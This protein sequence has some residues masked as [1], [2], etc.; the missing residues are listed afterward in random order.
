MR[1]SIARML[2][3][4][5]GVFILVSFGAAAC[6]TVE[7]QRTPEGEGAGQPPAAS[8]I[9]PQASTVPPASTVLPTSRR[10][11]STPTATT[12]TATRSPMP[13][14]S[15][16]PTLATVASKEIGLPLMLIYLGVDGHNSGVGVYSLD[17]EGRTRKLEHLSHVSEMLLSDDGS[18]VA[19]VDKASGQEMYI[20]DPGEPYQP[21]GKTPLAI[22]VLRT[23][24]SG[25]AARLT[26]EEL[27]SRFFEESE[28]TG[29]RRATYPNTIQFLPD[30]HELVFT[31]DAEWTE[32]LRG[33]PGYDDLVLM[34]GDTGELT[35][36]AA[37]LQDLS[38]SFGG[39][40]SIAPDGEYVL[41][42]YPEHINLIPTDG[43]RGHPNILTYERVDTGSDYFIYAEPVWLPDSSAAGVWIPCEQQMSPREDVSCDTKIWRILPREARAV[44]VG[45]FSRRP[46]RETWLYLSPDLSQTAILEAQKREW[47]DH[48]IENSLFLGGGDGS[49]GE[50][51]AQGKIT[52]TGWAPDAIHFMYWFGAEPE[53]ELTLMLGRID[54]D[55]EPIAPGA[56]SLEW[57]PDGRH[58]LYSSDDV[59]MLAG[60]DHP[61][62]GIGRGGWGTW[63]TEESYLFFDSNS[64]AHG[65]YLLGQI[66][67][68]MPIP[69]LP[70]LLDDYWIREIDFALVR[71]E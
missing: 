61:P 53:A 30:S 39:P 37:M 32:W 3:Q 18:L 7:E 43:P 34:D 66:G 51:Y 12:P 69:L 10:V 1:P 21:E 55:P 46:G 13:S 38:G 25:V 59:L 71:G 42:V 23:D 70:N 56:R 40:V 44:L 41:T 36:L 29:A 19:L 28:F 20:Q 33:H 35:D 9:S 22:L 24:G 52:W 50:L 63:V 68:R 47:P 57:S 26:V 65:A 6:G 8:R 4:V 2:G 62:V 64:G 11:S 14:P 16:G 31:T 67:D 5:A 49:G 48:P 54:G 45:E 58:F 17:P 27:N 15:P 60:I